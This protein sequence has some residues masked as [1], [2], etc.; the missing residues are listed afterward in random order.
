[1]VQLGERFL[2]AFEIAGACIIGLIF[3]GLA[4]TSESSDMAWKLVIAAVLCFCFALFFGALYITN[5]KER[6]KK[7]LKM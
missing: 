7:R 3:V 5:S 1:M 2:Y 6:E 4:V